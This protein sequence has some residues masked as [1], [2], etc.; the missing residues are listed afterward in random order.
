MTP[1]SSSPTLTGTSS[2]WNTAPVVPPMYQLATDQYS[3]PPAAEDPHCRAG[4]SVI[5]I[6]SCMARNRKIVCPDRVAG[7][8]GTVHVDRNEETCSLSSLVQC[9][10]AIQP[11]PR[12][13]TGS[14]PSGVSTSGGS[15]YPGVIAGF[16]PSRGT[17]P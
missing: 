11:R 1:V 4:K 17:E 6:V 10:N 14:L 8:G 15:A 12:G 13:V 9:A 2:P 5:G 3:P 7:S 16:A